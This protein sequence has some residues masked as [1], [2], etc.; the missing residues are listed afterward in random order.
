MSD[1]F[2]TAGVAVPEKGHTISTSNPVIQIRGIEGRESVSIW[3]AS[4]TPTVADRFANI[5]REMC[6]DGVYSLN[7]KFPSG[8][9]LKF[10]AYNT[11]ATTDISISVSEKLDVPGKPEELKTLDLT[12]NRHLCEILKEIRIISKYI[13]SIK[14]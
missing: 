8:F 7:S 3:A 6:E 2:I 10:I 12:A 4:K 14:D 11:S 13:K 5:T 9:K 1:Y